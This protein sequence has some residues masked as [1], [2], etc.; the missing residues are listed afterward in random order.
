MMKYFLAVSLFVAFV[1]VV[2]ADELAELADDPG[3]MVSNNVLLI[4]NFEIQKRPC[5]SFFFLV[6][7]ILQY[8][9]I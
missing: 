4:H 2:R 6:D 5:F 1:A 9:T 7:N 8:K 3:V